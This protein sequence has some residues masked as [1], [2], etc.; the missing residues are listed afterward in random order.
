MIRGSELRNCTDGTV[1]GTTDPLGCFR[2][3]SMW[4]QEKPCRGVSDDEEKSN[5]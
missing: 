1:D 2:T 3:D 5:Y 4:L